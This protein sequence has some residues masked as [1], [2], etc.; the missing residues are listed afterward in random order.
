MSLIPLA[1]DDGGGGVY[2]IGRGGSQAARQRRKFMTKLNF[3]T[4]QA[5]TL[6]VTLQERVKTKVKDWKEGG[7]VLYLLILRYPI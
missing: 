1:D 5:F 3:P 7:G 6:K 2:Y 4:K